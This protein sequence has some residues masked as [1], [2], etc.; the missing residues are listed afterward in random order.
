MEATSALMLASTA[1]C[2]F[3]GQVP[4]GQQAKPSRN[5]EVEVVEGLLAWAPDLKVTFSF[6]S[7]LINPDGNDYPTWNKWLEKLISSRWTF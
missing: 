1:Q 5:V 6:T 4:C 7:F 3:P 2:G